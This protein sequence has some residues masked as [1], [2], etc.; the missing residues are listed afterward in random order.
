MVAPSGAVF[1]ATVHRIER[2]GGGGEDA[3]SLIH[4]Y[5]QVDDGQQVCSVSRPAKAKT[6]SECNL[7]PPTNS[8]DRQAA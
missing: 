7:S 4:F 2:G 3:R 8:T 6:P 1:P 5:P